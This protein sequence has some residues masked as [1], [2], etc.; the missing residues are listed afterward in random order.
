MT[1]LAIARTTDRATNH[2]AA[3]CATEESPNAHIMSI[4]ALVIRSARYRP[5]DCVDER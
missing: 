2:G 3:A 5:C 4:T 1:P